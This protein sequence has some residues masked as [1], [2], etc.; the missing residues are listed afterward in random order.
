[1]NFSTGVFKNQRY[2]VSFDFFGHTHER[3]QFIYSDITALQIGHAALVLI[4]GECSDE[5]SF[6]NDNRQ[7][8]NYNCSPVLADFMNILS[9]HN[10][11][12]ENRFVIKII[13][14]I[15]NN[16]LKITIFLALPIEINHDPDFVGLVRLKFGPN[17]SVTERVDRH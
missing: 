14:K 12:L 3:Q 5:P 2:S 8:W 9:E 4:D 6:S 16:K 1:M 11:N 10:I 13:V 17:G 15:E 7:E